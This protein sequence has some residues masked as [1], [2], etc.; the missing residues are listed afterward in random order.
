MFVPILFEV[1]ISAVEAACPFLFEVVDFIG[2][3]QKVA[4][5]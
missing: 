3:I 1:S 2:L 5:K 4:R